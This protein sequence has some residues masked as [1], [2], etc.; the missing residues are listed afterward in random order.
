MSWLHAALS[1]S[2]DN[3]SHDRYCRSGLGRSLLTAAL[4]SL[5][6]TASGSID[7]HSTDGS[8]VYTA[9][10]KAS[11]YSSRLHGRKTASGEPYDETAFTAAHLDLPF[12]ARVC[13]T[14]MYNGRTTAVRVNDR[15]PYSGNRIIDLSFAA[16]KELGMLRAGTTRVKVESCDDADS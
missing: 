8:T 5:A 12:D 11:Y 2:A 13:I 6:S 4:L 3:P 1:R 15:G 16:A 7:E 9:T 14:N 10:G